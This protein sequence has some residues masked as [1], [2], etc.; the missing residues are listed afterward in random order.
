MGCI[1]HKND[2]ISTELFG[3]AITVFFYKKKHLKR[4]V[5]IWNKKPPAAV[6]ELYQ[7]VKQEDCIVKLLDLVDKIKLNGAEFS[8]V[9]IYLTH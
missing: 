1:L 3:K 6:P 5:E 4:I 7:E 8:K 2:K 9:C